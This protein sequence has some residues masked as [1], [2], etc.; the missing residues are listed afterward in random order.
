MDLV[1]QFILVV[2]LS[3]ATSNGALSVLHPPKKEFIRAEKHLLSSSFVFIG[4]V[5]VVEDSIFV[6]NL[7]IEVGDLLACQFL[8]IFGDVPLL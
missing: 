7:F 5:E 4:V 3:H 1:F 2:S 6:L 8:N